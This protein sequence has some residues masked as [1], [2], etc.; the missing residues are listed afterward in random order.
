MYRTNQHHR[1]AHTAEHIKVHSLIFTLLTC[2][3]RAR[4]R[5]LMGPNV[6][7]IARAMATTA[8]TVAPATESVVK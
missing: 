3:K 8:T 7:G 5:T 2:M 4:T 1:A 6:P